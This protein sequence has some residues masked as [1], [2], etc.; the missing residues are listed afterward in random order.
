MA[1]Y[2]KFLQKVA[3]DESAPTYVS[4]NGTHKIKDVKQNRLDYDIYASYV[5]SPF[6]E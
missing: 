1:Q 2:E 4:S 3:E 5:K 6:E